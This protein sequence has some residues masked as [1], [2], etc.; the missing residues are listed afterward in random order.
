ML[1]QEI[2][3]LVWAQGNL[4]ISMRWIL[5]NWILEMM[6]PLALQLEPC[7][8]APCFFILDRYLSLSYPHMT[9]DK[10]H[11]LGVGAI[12]IAGKLF[13]SY[14]IQ[15]EEIIVYCNHE[16]S[17]EQIVGIEREILQKL[18]FEI[19]IPTKAKPCQLPIYNYLVDLCAM[20]YRGYDF[21]LQ[22]VFEIFNKLSENQYN[23]DDDQHK[24]D[25]KT[26]ITLEILEEEFNRK[27]SP[28]NL[29]KYYNRKIPDLSVRI[30]EILKSRGNTAVLTRSQT[31]PHLCSFASTTS[32][33]SS[34]SISSTVRSSTKRVNE[35][36]S[37]LAPKKQKLEIT[38]QPITQKSRCQGITRCGKQCKRKVSQKFCNL[39][40]GGR[41]PP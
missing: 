21:S 32:A 6:S 34:S 38:L 28:T 40:E 35:R 12:F 23:I 3:Q 24:S 13:H 4:N 19:V 10:L 39:H 7:C 22:D 14:D 17:V 8:W 27:E 41:V 36:V 15:I 26:K 31:L 29:F 20:D 5:F 9:K 37:W 2:I 16:F 1:T 33:S 11:L 30:L 25:D 18:N